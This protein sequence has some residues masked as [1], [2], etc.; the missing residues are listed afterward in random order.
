MFFTLIAKTLR[1]TFK[2]SFFFLLTYTHLTINTFMYHFWSILQNVYN[3][4]VDYRV[5]FIQA[6][7]HK[8]TIQANN[9]KI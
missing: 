8:K 3:M 2:K 7:L 4:T 9:R 5:D 6:L 1:T